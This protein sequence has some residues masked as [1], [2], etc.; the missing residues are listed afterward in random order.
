MAN[1][2][3]IPYGIAGYDE[4]RRENYFYI[5]KTQYIA[6]L[7]VF[8]NP[9][10]L[11]PRRFGKT[12]LCT[13][14]SSYYDINKK[15]RFEELFGDTWIGK[16]TTSLQGKYMV[17]HLDFSIVYA[18]V[19]SAEELAKSFNN[20][21]LPRIKNFVGLEYAAYFKDFKYNEDITVWD[22][23]SEIIDY[24][25][26]KGLPQLY[27]II[28]EYDNFTNQLITSN[29]DSL[30][31]DILSGDGFL[32]T[33]FKIIKAGQPIEAIGRV[34]IT[35]VLPIT[36]DDLTSGYNIAELVTLRP[37]LAN[38]LGFTHKEAK[39]YLAAVFEAN[40]YDKETMPEIW[41]LLVNNYN[42]Y[43]FLPNAEPIFN[44]TILTYFFKIFTIDG[45][46]VPDELI[47]ENLR[48]DVSWIQRL[49]QNNES[50]IKM[51]EQVLTQNTLQYSVSELTSKFNRNKFINKNFFAIAM[52][53]LGM[54]T[55][56]DDYDMKLPN[57]TMKLIFTD[58]YNTLCDLEGD[59]DKYVPY[60]RQ[61]TKD[62]KI[63]GLME[64]YFQHYLGLFVA[65][66]FDKINENFVR[67]TFYELC[68]RYLKRSF[69]L[70][71]EQNYPSGRSDFEIAGRPGTA[72]YR[73][74][75]IVELKY[76]TSSE[77]KKI[78][79]LTEP[80]P[81]HVEK[82]N[83]YAR[84]SVQMLPDCK[85]H[86]HIIYLAGNKGFKYFVLNT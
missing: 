47:D 70:N 11:R 18:T 59:N 40:H 9:V 65:Q 71:M 55:L 46:V 63:E 13:T 17:L 2:I 61:F 4:I 74:K 69:F 15:H 57:N 76:F 54:T 42:G 36:I 64:C 80:S 20:A 66:S 14:L 53:Y 29:R 45:G 3:K 38:M 84:D 72:Y 83:G 81:E 60:F 39:H 7:E 58:Y 21:I 25:P 67:N 33:F 82:V 44:S 52:Y 48:T 49:A 78:N 50:A 16:N 26:Q 85:V 19:N 35:G 37:N 28:D 51:L 5:D 41:Q 8:K 10:F 34:F 30:Y 32:K 43:R 24:I 1:N 77:W 79:A 68:T 62:F 6:E 73:H 31:M 86:K 75:H 12:L 23:L 27:I 56:V 22:L